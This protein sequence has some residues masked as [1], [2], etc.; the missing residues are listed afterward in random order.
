MRC[1]FGRES[2][3]SKAWQVEHLDALDAQA[4][5]DMGDD[6]SL[7]NRA[8]TVSTSLLAISLRISLAICNI[9]TS[10]LSV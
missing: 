8:K 5:E 3:A 2:A 4:N 9:D 6:H 7:S 10:S 1:V